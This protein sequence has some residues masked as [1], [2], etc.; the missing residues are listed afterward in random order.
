MLDKLKLCNSIGILVDE[1]TDIGEKK[2]QLCIFVTY[3]YDNQPY[4]S[5]LKLI[6][7]EDGKAETI[8]LVLKQYLHKHTIY[9]KISAFR[10]DGANV[11]C[12]QKNC[13]A[14][15]LLKEYKE[16]IGI[17]CYAHRI[18]LIAS[19]LPEK[20]PEIKIINSV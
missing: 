19:N 18:N 8:F 9:S 5:F 15:L 7:L 17:H 1:S 10:S 16:I 2:K 6:E 13:V 11:V 14:G 3:L 4:T 12:S 20:F